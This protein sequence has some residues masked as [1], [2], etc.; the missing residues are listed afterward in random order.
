MR[1]VEATPVMAFVPSCRKGMRVE[2]RQ[3]RVKRADAKRIKEER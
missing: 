2:A 1:L 3:I